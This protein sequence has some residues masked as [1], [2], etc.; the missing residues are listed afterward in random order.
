MTNKQIAGAVCLGLV[1]AYVTVVTVAY[2][3]ALWADAL[4]YGVR[5]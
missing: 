5:R 2:V 1:G 3:V 4:M